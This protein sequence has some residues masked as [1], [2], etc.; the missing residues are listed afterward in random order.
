MNNKELLHR[1][2]NHLLSKAAGLLLV[3]VNRLRRVG[4]LLA[5]PPRRPRVQALLVEQVLWG[6]RRRCL[7]HKLRVYG[8][9]K[10]VWNNGVFGGLQE[11][12]CNLPNRHEVV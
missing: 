3:L 7:L 10:R 5:R 2:K 4:L 11:T 8:E 6:C 12:P 9:D 1:L